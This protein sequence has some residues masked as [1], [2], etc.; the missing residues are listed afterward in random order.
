ME[1]FFLEPNRNKPIT[2]IQVRLL[3]GQRIPIEA[4]LDTRVEDIHSHVATVSGVS[5]FELYG[6]FPP[7]LLSL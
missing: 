1:N 2:T 7:K 6:G 3:N 4:N 5:N